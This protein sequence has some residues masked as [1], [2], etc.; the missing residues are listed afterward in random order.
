[1]PFL[2]VTVSRPAG[3]ASTVSIHCAA[4]VPSGTSR[5]VSRPAG[6]SSG[7]TA[8]LPQTDILAF[9]R[10]PQDK[11]RMFSWDRVVGVVGDMMEPLD[12][13]PP[14]F[15]VSEFPTEEQIAAMGEEIGL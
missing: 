1:M 5:R 10:D 8:W 4:H 2:G 7:C 14:R 13:Y 15:R 6:C 12:M 3:R 11:P 9:M